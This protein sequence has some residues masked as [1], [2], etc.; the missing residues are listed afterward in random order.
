MLPV[1]HIVSYIYISLSLHH[2]LCA[3]LRLKDLLG[4]LEDV[5]GEA[6]AADELAD[7]VR[8]VVAVVLDQV[9]RAR[10]KHTKTHNQK[11]K[12]EVHSSL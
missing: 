7:L 1:S 8:K 3:H 10:S 9:P 11:N 5:L 12:L 4:K 6:G 2:P